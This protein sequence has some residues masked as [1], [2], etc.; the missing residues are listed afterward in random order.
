MPAT[1]ADVPKV[2]AASPAVTETTTFVEGPASGQPAGAEARATKPEPSA[3]GPLSGFSKQT[4]DERV[5]AEA[6]HAL[7]QDDAA[8]HKVSPPTHTRTKR[9]PGA[10]AA[11][12]GLLIVIAIVVVA[13]ISTR[14][15]AKI[16]SAN[17]GRPGPSGTIRT[18]KDDPEPNTKPASP[19]PTQTAP[20]VGSVSTA[21]PSAPV[22][23]SEP[24]PSVPVAKPKSEPA[25]VEKRLSIAE[26]FAR[27]TRAPRRTMA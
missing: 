6:E 10:L 18:G 20:A 3:G 13:L 7:G 23:K 17:Q 26:T 25:P 9:V 14:E 2:C 12:V 19:K 15:P 1:P 21:P 27:S 22:A 8:A 11:G 16:R 4:S 24:T 5:P